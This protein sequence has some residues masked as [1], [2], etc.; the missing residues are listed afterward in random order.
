ME[1]EKAYDAVVIAGP[2]AVGKTG[3]SIPVAKALGAEIISMDSRLVYRGLDIGTDKPGEEERGGVPHHLID[4]AAPGERFTV[5]DFTRE[6]REAMAEISRRGRLPLIVGGTFLYLNALRKGFN[7]CD[8]DRDPEVRKELEEE[9][10]ERGT[11]AMHGELAAMDPESAGRIHPND[12]YRI[13]R[14]LEVLRATGT[15]PSAGRKAAVDNRQPPPRL[16]VTAL[17]LPRNILCE[18]INKRVDSM[19]NRKLIGETEKILKESSQAREL[20]SNVIGYAQALRVLEGRT[21]L[22]EAIEET[23]KETRHFARRQMVWLRGMED[24]TWVNTQGKSAAETASELADY[25][26]R[27]RDT[28]TPA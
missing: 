18:R 21:T 16:L 14:A 1:G 3:I 10:G 24:V 25:I 2:T 17:Y 11:E 6:C 7:F 4:V 8:T 9:A 27:L 28:A 23:K 15:P 26:K 22:E 19:Y 5:A 12:R 20:L 13:L